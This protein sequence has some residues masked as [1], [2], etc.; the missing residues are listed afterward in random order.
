MNKKTTI[1]IVVLLIIV[2]GAGAWVYGATKSADTTSTAH[3]DDQSHAATD[4]QSDTSDTA[5]TAAT[6]TA[7]NDGFTP[8]TV[9]VKKG[10][11]I[12][13]VNNSSSPIEFSSADHPTHLEDPELNMATLKPGESGTV[14][15]EKVGTHGYHDH[16]HADHTGSITVTE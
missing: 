15:P 4:S 1:W 6:I 12:K 8:N 7:T 16:L 11:S 3:E 10:Q 14:T 13:I 2:A 9:T 5:V